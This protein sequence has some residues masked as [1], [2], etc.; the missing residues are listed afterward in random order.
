MIGYL[1]L[2]LVSLPPLRVKIP[3]PK[4]SK[5]GDM[6]TILKEFEPVTELVGVKEP[7]ANTVVLGTLLRGKAKAVYNNL[8]GARGRTTLETVTER[9]I[10]DFDSLV[11]REGA[12]QKLAKLSINVNPL[13]LTVEL[14]MLLRRALP[15]LSEESK[16]QFIGRAGHRFSEA[17]TSKSRTTYEYQ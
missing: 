13:V 3:W 14:T 15:N 1:Q 6:L 8:N 2:H 17:E 5:D 16:E 11:D 4:K 7:R 10:A 9:L 12:L